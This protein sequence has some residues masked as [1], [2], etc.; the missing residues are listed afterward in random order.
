MRRTA[1]RGCI[2]S[3]DPVLKTVSLIKDWSNPESISSGAMGNIQPL[4]G[5][6]V[7]D[8]NIIIGWGSNP[9]VTEHSKDDGSVVM[10][11]QVGP[12]AP[13]FLIGESATTYRA[14]KNNWVGTPNTRV[15][16]SSDWNAQQIF[17]S[18]NGATEVRSW[19]IVSSAHVHRLLP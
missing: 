10:D 17:V 16:I 13:G 19:A 15:S 3:L 2:F 1:A 14:Y 5:Y 4:T 6:G 18:W 8:G 7:P 11:I 12:Y 9:S